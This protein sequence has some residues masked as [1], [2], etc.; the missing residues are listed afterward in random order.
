MRKKRENKTRKKLK[1]LENKNITKIKNVYSKTK[2]GGGGGRGKQEN[3][4]INTIKKG[5]N[6]AHPN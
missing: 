2:G 5:E 4:N 6:I 1:S 3:L